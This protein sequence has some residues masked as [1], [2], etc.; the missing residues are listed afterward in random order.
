[1]K[2]IILVSLTLIA[3][4]VVLGSA[5]AYDSNTIGF[6]QCLIQSGI[7]ILVAWLSLRELNK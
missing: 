6:G 5:G 3:L 4:I 2:N 7:A 1:M